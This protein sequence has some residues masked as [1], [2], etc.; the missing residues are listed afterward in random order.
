MYKRLFAQ[1][2]KK[3]RKNFFCFY[4]IGLVPR[5]HS[6][7]VKEKV[8]KSRRNFFYFHCFVFRIE[9]FIILAK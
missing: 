5:K 3:I 7:K 4:Y 6:E 8:R 2:N 9:I 1:K